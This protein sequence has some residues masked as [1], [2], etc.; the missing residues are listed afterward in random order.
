MKL[1]IDQALKKGVEAHKAGKLQEAD[2]HYTAILTVQP[3][4][5]DANHNMGLLAVGLGKVQEALPFFKIALETN[6]N[7][8]EFW[9]SCINALIKLN[10]LADAKAVFNDAISKGVKGDGFEQ[11]EKRLIGLEKGLEVNVAF[12]KVKEPPEDQLQ[13][14]INLYTQGLFQKALVQGLELLKDFPNSFNLYN[15]I[16]AVNKGLGKL[17]EAIEA[18]NKAL[19]L[20]P[21]YAEA[22]N[23]M[24][25]VLQDQSRLEEAEVYKK[26]I[27]I[28]SDF[29]E[30]YNNMGTALQ[31]QGN[32]EEAIEAYNKAV[33]IQPDYANAYNNM[34]TAQKKQGKLD[35]AIVSY[36]KALVIKPD[37]AEVYNNMGITLKIKGKLVEAVEAYNKALVI[38]P[39]YAEVYNNMGCL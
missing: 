27:A 4:H 17:D 23:N 36:T 35:K 10:L 11:I 29:A 5:P 37:Y 30:A 34:G 39:K 31:D 6:P 38:K 2:R 18:Y 16:G 26:A 20:K 33:T 13:N 19:L 7:N 21:D 32:L 24:G 9:I 28:E 1:K 25:I 15:I 3:K 8:A 22:H 12:N 14:L